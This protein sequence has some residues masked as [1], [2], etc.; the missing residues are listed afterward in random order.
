[1]TVTDVVRTRNDFKVF[2]MTAKDR[3]IAERELFPVV[4]FFVYNFDSPER[5]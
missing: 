2:V 4:N 3:V 1:M 5:N